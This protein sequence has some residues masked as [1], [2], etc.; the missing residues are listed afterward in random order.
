M[1]NKLL[2]YPSL[3][4]MAFAYSSCELIGDIFKAG[5]WSA[6]IVIGLVIGII[7]YLVNKMGRRKNNV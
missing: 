3:L 6:F 2:F 1:R 5:F 7:I 4:M